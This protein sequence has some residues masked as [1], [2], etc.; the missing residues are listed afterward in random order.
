M[1]VISDVALWHKKV[2]RPCSK[3]NKLHPC[4]M[5]VVKVKLPNCLISLL[6]EG[7][8]LAAC[9]GRFMRGVCVMK[10]SVSP[11]CDTMY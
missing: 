9:S 4:V 11:G 2:G 5:W 6:D 3:K 1:P 8:C 7:G 10:Y